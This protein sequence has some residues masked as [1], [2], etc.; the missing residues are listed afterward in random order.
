MLA[1]DSSLSLIFS[2]VR[3]LWPKVLF[4]MAKFVTEKGDCREK[5]VFDNCT[6]I[7]LNTNKNS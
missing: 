5:H 7:Q 6:D 1:Q 4:T 3:S 2:N